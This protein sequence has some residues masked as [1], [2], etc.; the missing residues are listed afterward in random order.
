MTAIGGRCLH[1]QLDE[2][3]ALADSGA[4]IDARMH[5]TAMLRC[6]SQLN[7]RQ[8]VSCSDDAMRVLRRLLGKPE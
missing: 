5:L 3:A 8:A 4:T 6:A 7:C 1:S 2:I